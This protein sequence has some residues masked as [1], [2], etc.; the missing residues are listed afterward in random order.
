[1]RLTLHAHTE[2]IH[3]HIE[4]GQQVPFSQ[5]FYAVALGFKT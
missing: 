3:L 2:H 5:I 4:W 1:M